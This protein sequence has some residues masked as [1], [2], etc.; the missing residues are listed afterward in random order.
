MMVTIIILLIITIL[1]TTIKV[2]SKI[3]KTRRIMVENNVPQ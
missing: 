3:I 1:V 2:N